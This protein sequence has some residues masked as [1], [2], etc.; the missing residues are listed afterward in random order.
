MKIAYYAFGII[1]CIGIAAYLTLLLALNKN[2]GLVVAILF[3]L[4]LAINCFRQ[5]I[6][7]I[8][9]PAGERQNEQEQTF[10]TTK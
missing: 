2:Y 3:D 1:F 4:A 9:E 7:L 10:W 5:M 8:T 6:K